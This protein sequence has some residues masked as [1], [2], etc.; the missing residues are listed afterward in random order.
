MSQTTPIQATAQGDNGARLAIR[1]AAQRTGVDFDYLLAQAK[2]ESSLDPSARARTS[3]ATG[4]Y[5]FINSTWLSVLDRHGAALGF[6]EEAAAIETRGG[7][8]RVTDPAQRASIMA[9]RFDPHAS[10]MMAAALAQDNRAALVPVLGRE[11]QPNEL[12]LAHFLGAAGASR[13]L[14][15][16]QANPDQSAA[17]LMPDAAAANRTIFYTRSG[18]PR[19]LGEVHDVIARKVARAMESGGAAQEALI[20]PPALASA[21][22][23]RKPAASLIPALGQTLP[24]LPGQG[25]ARPMAEVLKTT[26]AAAGDASG[27]RAQAHASRAYRQLGAF[28]L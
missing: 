11:P 14:G 18:V 23:A 8:A 26:F 15:Q 19:S 9:L 5:Q 4:L 10:A 24:P 17:A 3:S 25:A 12:Y 27:S 16:M 1:Q 7:K 6:A 20:P 13:F 28:G 21:R 22:T 2:L